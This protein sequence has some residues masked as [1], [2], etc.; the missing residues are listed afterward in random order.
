VAYKIKSRSG[1]EVAGKWIISKDE[2]HS[3]V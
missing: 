2:T 3:S 1:N